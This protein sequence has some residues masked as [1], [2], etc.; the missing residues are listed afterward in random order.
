METKDQ[1][2]IDFAYEEFEPFCKWRRDEKCDFFE[3]Y[4]LQGSFF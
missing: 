1:P 3:I 4:G 2:A